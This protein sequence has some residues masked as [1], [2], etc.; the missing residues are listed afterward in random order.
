MKIPKFYFFV[1]CFVLT[2]LAFNS[3]V[4]GFG[5]YK[6]G[7]YYQ[8][9][10]EAVDR[11]RSKPDH[12]K[13]Q[14]VLTSAY[15]MALKSEQR[16]IDQ[17]K[18]S[19]SPDK[20]DALV[21]RYNRLNNLATNIY[22]CPKAY[23]LIPN[24]TEFY[25]ELNASKQDAAAQ[26][27]A[28]GM[29]YMSS[30]TI[31][32]ARTA[33]R[34][35]LHVNDYVKDYRDVADKIENARYAGTLRVIVRKPITN[36]RYQLSADFF[37]TNLINE[38]AQATKNRLVRFY[39][40][41]EAMRE[42]MQNPHQYLV[43]NFEDFSVGDVRESK[44][45]REL[46]RDSVVVGT[47]KVEGKTYNAYNTVKADF[48][49]FRREISSGGVLSVQIIDAYNNRVFDYKNFTGQ[50]V[51]FTEWASFKGDDRALADA[52]KKLCGR[53]PDVPPADQDLFIEFTKPIYSQVVSYVRSAYN[54]Y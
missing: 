20:Y 7:D 41:D 38:M 43:M 13:A 15:P 6:R 12:K 44:N 45:T 2:V 48:T 36:R 25:K 29:K 54:K 53:Q 23:E 47:V 16:E 28:L 4:S 39:T 22:N 14:Y 46:K 40:P 1:F 21:E 3:C 42:K 8:A 33:Y 9:C 37:F 27:Y 50:Y 49:T 26:N 17:L 32:D 30:G 52:Q 10:L 34:Y 19:Q 24:P 18:I 51:W 35:F 11:L 5:S 31:D